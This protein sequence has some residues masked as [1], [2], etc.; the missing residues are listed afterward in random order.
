M[1]IL[2]VATHVYLTFK[3]KFIQRYIFKAIK[4]SVKKDESAGMIS[5][6][7]SLAVSLAAT[8]GTGSIIGMATAIATGGPGAVFWMVVIG[9]FGMSTKYSECLLAIKYRVKNSAGEY[10]GGPMYIMQNVLKMK[11]M[12]VIFAV[13]GLFM[14]LSGGGMLQVNSIADVLGDAYKSNNILVGCIVACAVWVVI[15]GGV[16]SIA[17]ACEWLVPIM[18]VMYL[19]AALTIFA[20]HFDAVPQVLALIFKEAFSF[21]SAGGGFLGAGIMA[22]MHV[23]AS[24]SVLSTEAG[25]GSAAVV[26]A[27]AK[28][29]NP[30]RQGLIA[31][32]SVFWTFCTCTL[33]G[34]II[35]TAGDWQSGGK[36]SGDLCNSAFSK[37]P[38]FGVPILVFSLVIFSFTTIIGWTYY[39]EKFI[40]FLGGHKFV[41]PF[42]IF[43]IISM[44]LGAVMSPKFAWSLAVF[45]TAMMSLPNLL[46]I[47]LLRNDIVK[48]TD[49]YLK[50]EI[51]NI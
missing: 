35:L 36:F 31:S 25:L 16:K 29:E 39:G 18:G 30:V 10:V 20:I 22:A 50:K 49:K 3:F 27:A 8:I 42:R 17:K 2:L 11:R 21:K 1:I 45:I 14:A 15:I 23:G 24:R 41:K 28:T 37:I 19:I 38:Y 40:E 47:F 44:A 12:G 46:M 43:W 26:A 6:F 51:E 7:G 34:L 48:E 33:T 4:L 5:N 13:C 9:V 32:T